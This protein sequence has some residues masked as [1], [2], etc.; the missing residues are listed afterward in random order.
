MN[1]ITL[2]I[3][4]MKKLEDLYF[5]VLLM[6]LKN[7]INKVCNIGN[8]CVKECENYGKCCHM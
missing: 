2:D 8:Y 5:N 7:G 1:F 3:L 4:K 6:I